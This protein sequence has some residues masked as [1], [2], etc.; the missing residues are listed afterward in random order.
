MA[1]LVAMATVH[2]KFQM[3]FPIK[4]LSQFLRNLIFSIYVIDI[5]YLAKISHD[6]KFK[7]AAIPI[8]GKNHSNDFYPKPIGRLG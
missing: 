7:M 8:Y 2:V 4:E 6:L 5:R 1:T 3:T